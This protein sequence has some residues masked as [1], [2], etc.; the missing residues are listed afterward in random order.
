MRKCL[1]F[2]TAAL[3][4]LAVC[5]NPVMVDG[6]SLLAFGIV[7][8]WA[9]VIE[10]AI[11][12][13]ILASCGLLIVPFFGTL[14]IANVSVFLFAFLPLASQAPL[15]L[16]ESG[17]VLVDALVIKLIASAPLFQSGNYGGVGFWR[18]LLAS[19]LGNTASYFIGVIVNHQPWIVHQTGPAG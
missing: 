14:V 1:L 7:A 17:V 19:F 3:F 16:L 15:W 10:S 6:Q 2:M 9:L 13:L 11:V 5:A 18:A 4:P 12:T 8:F